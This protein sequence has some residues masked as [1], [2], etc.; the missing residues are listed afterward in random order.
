MDLLVGPC[1]GVGRGELNAFP[2]KAET[3]CQGCIA[4]RSLMPYFQEKLRT[5]KEVLVPKT[6]TG[7]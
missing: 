5:F 7:G 2:T 3:G 1:N 6:D 4:Y